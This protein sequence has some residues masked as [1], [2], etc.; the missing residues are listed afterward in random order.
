MSSPGSGCWTSRRRCWSW[1]GPRWRAPC[2]G[3]RWQ[4][5]GRKDGRTE[6]QKVVLEEGTRARGHSR[7]RA[8]GSSGKD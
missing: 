2:R 7:P 3:G 4:E 6:R 1:Q 8:S 5:E